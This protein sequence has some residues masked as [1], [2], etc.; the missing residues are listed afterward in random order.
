M[1]YKDFNEPRFSLERQIAFHLEQINKAY[2]EMSFVPGGRNVFYE[3]AANETQLNY[4]MFV[5]DFINKEIKRAKKVE[6]TA[7]HHVWVDDN[8]F[9]IK[10]DK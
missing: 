9:D 2:T 6:K 10:E 4:L 3:A 1:D 5:R 8:G 7:R